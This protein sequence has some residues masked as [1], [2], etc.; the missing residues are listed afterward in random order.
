MET[1]NNKIEKNNAIIFAS[2]NII[3][4]L[5]IRFIST[6]VLTVIYYYCE[7]LFVVIAWLFYRNVRLL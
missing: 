6:I 7:V 2:Q 1:K 5:I 4:N 3:M